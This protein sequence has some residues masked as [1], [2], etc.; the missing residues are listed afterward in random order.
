[1]S[2]DAYSQ[3]QWLNDRKYK[4]MEL[5][6][7]LVEYI[8]E[9]KGKLTIRSPELVDNHLVLCTDDETYTMRQMNHS[10][11]MLLMNDM[12][13]NQLGTKFTGPES[14]LV[15]IDRSSYMYELTKLKG[16]I[17]TANIPTYPSGNA[18]ESKTMEQLEN[19]SPIDEGHFYLQWYG[20]CGSQVDGRAV[21]LEPSFVTEALYTVISVLLSEKKADQEFDFDTL[22]KRC[23]VQDPKLTEDFVCTISHRF[24][25]ETSPGKFTL[26]HAKCA[27]W[28]GV[29]TMK[30]A[31]PALLTEKEF[32][33]KW[34]LGLPPFFNASLDLSLLRG[35]FCRPEIG[36]I[37]YL[38]SEMLSSDLHTR[39][40]ELFQMLKEWDY[41]EFLAFI[42][43]FIPPPKKADSIILKYAKK[44]RISKNKFIVCPR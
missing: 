34:K 18:E 13:I 44:K 8:E 30:N 17:D 15:A 29:E 38:N 2:F 19:D 32:M 35:R 42:E 39:I 20:L 43:A 41:D 36:K 22:A 27:W 26:N 37:R 14:A 5:L 28:F 7:E 40:K 33:L 12:N 21:I 10:N 9:N 6:D 4:L 31:S 3:V 25:D 24:G 1:M 11:T 16:Y 23:L